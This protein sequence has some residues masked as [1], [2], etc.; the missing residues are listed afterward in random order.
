MGPDGLEPVF[1]KVRQWQPFDSGTVLA[2]ISTALDERAP[3]EERVKEATLRW[4]GHLK[5][6]ADIADQADESMAR[7]VTRARALR[8]QVTP[9]DYR[10]AVG[11]L[12]PMAWTVKEL[13]ERL[14]ELPCLREA[15]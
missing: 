10:Q 1:A 7:S 5:R 11:R 8:P 12:R 15:V 13:L 6:L 4:R 3:H 14:V 2:D 9:S